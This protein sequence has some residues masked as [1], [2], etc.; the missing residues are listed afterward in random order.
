MDKFEADKIIRK[1]RLRT[2]ALF[3]SDLR[4]LKNCQQLSA[5]GAHR[6]SQVLVTW[7]SLS[8]IHP[9]FFGGSTSPTTF[10]HME[11]YRPCPPQGQRPLVSL[12][13]HEENGKLSPE[14]SNKWLLCFP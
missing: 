6:L 3:G 7:W 2:W 8:F 11:Q 14:P 13:S 4:M 12:G 1:A 5:P 10:F 9:L